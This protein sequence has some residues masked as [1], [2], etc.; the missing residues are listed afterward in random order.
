MSNVCNNSTG[1][2][3]INTSEK[4]STNTISSS[5]RIGK[6]SR[7]SCYNSRLLIS[8]TS[9]PFFSSWFFW[10]GGGSIISSSKFSLSSSNLRSVFDSNWEGEVENWSS[11]RSNFRS[12]KG[13]G[14]VGSSNSESVDGVSNIINSLEKTVSINVLVRASGYSISITGLSTG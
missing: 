2:S 10:G 8:I 11:K 14:K 6:N 12:C 5:I 7:G 9:L 1:G 13:N 4:T 3:S